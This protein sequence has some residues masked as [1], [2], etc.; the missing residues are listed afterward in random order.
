MGSALSLFLTG[1][2]VQSKL[3]GCVEVMATAWRSDSAD[4]VCNFPDGVWNFSVPRNKAWLLDLSDSE[5]KR[6]SNLDGL[7][8][9]RVLQPE[10][11]AN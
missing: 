11:Q 3:N 8:L 4:A 9:K 10:F 1:F 7:L 5:K 6:G 2:S